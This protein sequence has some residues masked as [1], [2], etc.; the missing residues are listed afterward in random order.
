MLPP[1]SSA[2]KFLMQSNRYG[3]N[4]DMK[5]CSECGAKLAGEAPKFCGECGHRLSRVN[6][7]SVSTVSGAHA[8]QVDSA[9]LRRRAG[10][11]A[12]VD[13]ANAMGERWSA[14]GKKHL[15][16]GDLVK[17]RSAF[18]KGADLDHSGCITNLGYVLWQLGDLGEARRVLE[19]AVGMGNPL[20]MNNLAIILEEMGDTQRSHELYL[21]SAE[22]GEPIGMRNLGIFLLSLDGDEEGRAWLVKAAELGD[23]E[24]HNKLGIICD[25][26][27]DTRQAYEHF[28]AGGTGP[29]LSLDALYNL[30]VWEERYGDPDLAREY[31]E[32]AAEAGHPKAKEEVFEKRSLTRVAPQSGAHVVSNRD[33]VLKS[34][35]SS[36][37]AGEFDEAVRLLEPL[38]HAAD[39][40][41]MEFLG[42]VKSDLG[43]V[44]EAVHWFHLASQH[45]LSRGASSA[46]TKALQPDPDLASVADRQVARRYFA[47][48]AEAGNTEDQAILAHLCITD[49][50]YDCARTWWM[51][52]VADA[53]VDFPELVAE[54]RA[55]LDFMEHDPGY[56]AHM[57]SARV[58]DHR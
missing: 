26:E 30:S 49:N 52:I 20:A 23:A 11:I 40:E 18:Q 29:E 6:H 42:V 9:R 55:N 24:A 33:Q 34:A 22:A 12:S 21:S 38:A 10:E 4:L 5:F 58:G 56:I 17:A 50:D 19:S 37:L 31:L 8:V 48:S 32:E 25:Q 16:R 46:G 28:Y 39:A 27:G 51:R 54:A 3:E 53:N 35:Q 7:E 44:D 45:G 43:D 13:E 1:K 14:L 57:S 15:T 36:A 41:A 2:M 47:I